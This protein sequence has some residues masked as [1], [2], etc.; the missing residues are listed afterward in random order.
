M[1]NMPD[2]TAEVKLRLSAKYSTPHQG[3]YN[4]LFVC[5]AFHSRGKRLSYLHAEN[6]CPYIRISR[7]E[8]QC[9]THDWGLLSSMCLAFEN[10]SES[11]VFQSVEFYRTGSRKSTNLE[12]KRKEA[13][14]V[15]EAL[16]TLG[17][18]SS[19]HQTVLLS[20]HS[21]GYPELPGTGSECVTHVIYV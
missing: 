21:Q 7:R 15:P 9:C 12:K 20:V 6:Q 10:R 17:P 8:S 1:Q 4:A 11:Y 2:I 14:F 13:V 19:F 3:M 16:L 18:S 5:K